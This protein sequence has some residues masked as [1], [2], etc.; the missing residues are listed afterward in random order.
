MQAMDW[1][2]LPDGYW[3]M[4]GIWKHVQQAR[5]DGVRVC[6]VLYDLIP[7]LN[8]EFF[9]ARSQAGFVAYLERMMSDVDLVMCISKTVEQDYRRYV[10]QQRMKTGITHK[11]TIASF[12]LGADLPNCSAQDSL[13]QPRSE[14][15]LPQDDVPFFLQVGTIE[16]RKNHS[17]ILD[18]VEKLW[19]RGVN[20]RC[21]FVGRSGWMA[22]ALLLRIATH[23][24]CNSRLFHFASLDDFALTDLYRKC[25]AVLCP[26]LAEGFGLPIVEGLFAGKR[27]IASDIPIH[28]EVGQ[29]A[30]LYFDV[31]HLAALEQLMEECLSP[32]G[33]MNETEIGRFA[34]W[35]RAI[36]TWRNSAAELL[37]HIMS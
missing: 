16:P 26:S 19:L 4:N 27:V 14:S 28:R 30:C 9:P 22:D 3:A 20:V 32:F 24:E 15:L 33:G 5:N 18:A 17:I 6:A 29:D 7:V 2:I 31:H 10:D 13:L 34:S 36:T 12:R 8:P 35:S 25:H 11:Q 21:V 37:S 23:S 1:L